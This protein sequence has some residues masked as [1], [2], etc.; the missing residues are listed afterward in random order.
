MSIVGA[1]TRG[2]ILLS[3]PSLTDGLWENALLGV[4]QL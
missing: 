3:K 4:P 1:G 2:H